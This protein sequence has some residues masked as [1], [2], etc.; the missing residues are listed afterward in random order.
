MTT[1]NKVWLGKC[2]WRCGVEH[3]QIWG[4]VIK[5]KHGEQW[6]DWSTAVVRRPHGCSLQKG[7]RVGCDRFFLFCVY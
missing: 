2:L 6:R 3:E 7:I 1:L 4:G 5:A